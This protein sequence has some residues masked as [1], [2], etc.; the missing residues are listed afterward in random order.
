MIASDAFE[1][2]EEK[3]EG[4]YLSLGEDLETIPR[5]WGLGVAG[6]LDLETGYREVCCPLVYRYSRERS[7]NP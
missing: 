4:C 3:G 5:A 6:L 7:V 1:D 2:L